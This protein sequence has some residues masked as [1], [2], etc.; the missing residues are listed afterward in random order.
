MQGETSTSQVKITGVAALWFG[1]QKL[2]SDGDVNWI[3]MVTLS[4][5]R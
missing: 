1:G 4:P 5:G 2:T 3:P